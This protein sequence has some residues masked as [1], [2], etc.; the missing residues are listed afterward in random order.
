MGEFIEALPIG[1]GC[2][3][4]IGFPPELGRYIVEKGS[5]AVDG[6]SLTVAALSDQWLEIAIIPQTWRATNLSLL[7][8]GEAVNLEVDIL[9]KYVERLLQSHANEPKSGLTLEKLQELGY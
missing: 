9:A 6:I 5:I 2:V 8:R 7:K 4:R 3:V 1:E